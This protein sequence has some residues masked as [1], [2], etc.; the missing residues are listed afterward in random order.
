MELRLSQ[1]SF[2]SLPIRIARMSWGLIG[3]KRR[4]PRSRPLSKIARACRERLR[5][6]RA[7]H[8]SDMLNEQHLAG[9]GARVRSR[10]RSAQERAVVACGVDQSARQANHLA[11]AQLRKL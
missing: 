4:S 8:T 10:E 2:E 3:R 7:L 5:T 6:I 11:D 1:D 9:A